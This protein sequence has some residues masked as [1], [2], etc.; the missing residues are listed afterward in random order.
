MHF[1]LVVVYPF[2]RIIIGKTWTSIN[3]L[4]QWFDYG[5]LQ[6][7]LV[8]RWDCVLQKCCIYQTL[9]YWREICMR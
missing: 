3:F 6:S 9:E 5:E 2:L 1:F 7:M 4:R 8:I